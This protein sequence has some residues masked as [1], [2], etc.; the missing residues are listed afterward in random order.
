MVSQTQ[1]QY[2]TLPA[3]YSAR[4][5]TLDDVQQCI[6]LFNAYSMALY[7]TADFRVVW[8]KLEFSEPGYDPSASTLMVFAPDGQLV[9]YVDVF[10]N[11]EIPVHPFLWLCVHPE[12]ETLELGGYLHQ[13]GVQRARQAIAR[14]P[15]DA[16]VSVRSGASVKHAYMRNLHETYGMQHVRT[17]WGMRIDRPQTWDAPSI[18]TGVTV[19]TMR[20]PEEF[21]R[22]AYATHDAFRDHYGHIEQNWEEEFKYWQHQADN[23]PAFD[24]SLWFIAVDDA[25]GEIVATSLCQ[26][27]NRNNPAWGY[28]RTLAVVRAWRKRGLGVAMLNHTFNHFWQQ[29]KEAVMLGVDASNITGAT[30]LYEKAGMYVERESMT[31]ELELRPGKELAVV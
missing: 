11:D 27:E 19:R 29:G 8:L 20:Y 21:E 1:D 31:Y 30:R 14:C 24:P 6:D 3:G 18:P 22:T 5:A 10:D 2:R 7:G 12:H 26:G 17:W 9:G 23:D 4:P 25:T 28:I 16:L 15:A 13:W